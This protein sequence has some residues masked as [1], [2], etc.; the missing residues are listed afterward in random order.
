[1]T[2]RSF[3]GQGAYRVN[4]AVVWR[5][6]AFLPGEVSPSC[7]KG[8]RFTTVGEKSAEAIERVTNPPEGPNMKTKGEALRFAVMVTQKIEKSQPGT[9]RGEALVNFRR[10]VK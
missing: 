4:P 2:S 6:I 3:C 1:M 8:Q 10:C 9:S 5:R 7:L